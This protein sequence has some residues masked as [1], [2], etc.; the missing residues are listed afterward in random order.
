MRNPFFLMTTKTSAYFQT[1][2]LCSPHNSKNE[3]TPRKN[4]SKEQN[5]RKRVKEVGMLGHAMADR[6]VVVRPSEQDGG[7]R[8][9][10]SATACF[11]F[12]SKHLPHTHT[13]TI[14]TAYGVCT[15]GHPVGP[16]IPDHVTSDLFSALFLTRSLPDFLLRFGC[17]CK[18]FKHRF[19]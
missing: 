16:F 14:H 4:K 9:E 11:V 1:L 19:I 3:Q 10:I 18:L 17:V 15:P 5:Q 7:Y 8:G 2:S 6:R 13:L 12:I